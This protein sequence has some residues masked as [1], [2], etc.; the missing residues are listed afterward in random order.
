LADLGKKTDIALG[1]VGSMKG[2]ETG[3]KI[4]DNFCE[5]IIAFIKREFVATK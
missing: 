3:N 5:P 1:P 4:V 2:H